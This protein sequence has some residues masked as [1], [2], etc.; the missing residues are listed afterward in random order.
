[1]S[2]ASRDGTGD[3]IHLDRIVKRFDGALALNHAS[4]RVTRGTVHGLVGQNGAGK[5]TLIKLLAGLHQPDEGRI[6]IDGQAYDKL[7]PH[8][9][10]ELGIHFIHQDR[11]LVPTFTVGEALFLGRE[12]RIAGTP[13]LDRR[14]M[15]RRAGEI[16]GDYFG[17][18]LPNSAL[19]SEL[20]TAEKQIVQITRALLDQ[21]KVLVFDE[22]TAALV[23]READILFRLIRRLRDE[24]VTIIY[25]SHYLNEIEELCDTVTV[26]RNG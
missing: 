18:R 4:L 8:R 6:E 22:P 1:M 23:R 21:P 20:S 14:L 19:I 17:V 15:Q 26:L 9:V 5:S 12:P 7:T 16:L 11:L 24:G 3:A 25:I 2:A 10:E 13:F